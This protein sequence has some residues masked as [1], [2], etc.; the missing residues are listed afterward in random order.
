[1]K[2]RITLYCFMIIL[3]AA[4]FS[5]ANHNL[6]A[7][8]TLGIPFLLFI[9]QSWVISVLQGVGY[10]ASIAWIYS[11]YNYIQFR[12]SIGDDWIR[13]AII[14]FTVALYSAWTGF[15]L[16]SSHIK[17]VYGMTT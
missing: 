11:A 5:R 17:N 9:K 4:H 12:I 1:M 8:I 7:I 15:F 16:R 14:L 2:T 6:L 3:L 10:L 13:L